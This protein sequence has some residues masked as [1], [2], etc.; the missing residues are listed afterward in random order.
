MKKIMYVI[1]VIA[2]STTLLGRIKIKPNMTPIS[3]TFTTATTENA[4]S[5]LD[6]FLSDFEFKNKKYRLVTTDDNVTYDYIKS[7]LWKYDNIGVLFIPKTKKIICQKE[8]YGITS[9]FFGAGEQIDTIV[10]KDGVCTKKSAER[11]LTLPGRVD[12]SEI[13]SLSI[14]FTDKVYIDK[15]NAEKIFK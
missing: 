14:D 10:R 12:L 9:A 4:K 3:R 6:K 7:K 2:M 15:K 1:L 13:E 11:A 8:K 5:V